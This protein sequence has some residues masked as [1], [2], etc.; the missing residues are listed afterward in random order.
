MRSEIRAYLQ[1]IDVPVEDDYERSTSET[2][3]PDGSHY[4]LELLPT[5]LD[6]YER[7]VDLASEHATPVNKFVDVTGTTFDS[8]ET[9]REKCRRCRDAGVQLLM[10]PGRGHHACDVSQQMALGEMDGGIVR[11][12]DNLVHALSEVKRASDLG[13]R[14]FNFQDEGLFRLC[15]RMRAD[16][17]LPADTVLKL[18]SSFSVSNPSSVAF[19]ADLLEPHDSVNLAR[20]LTLPML[21]AIRNVTDQPLDVHAFWHTEVVRT[22]DTPEI[23]RVAAPVSLKNYRVDHHGA[24]EITVEEQYEQSLRVA[25]TIDREFPEAVQFEATADTPGVPGT[26]VD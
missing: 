24:R 2:R 7:I 8:D 21:S 11:G 22:Q 13:C 25:E 18:S 12:M 23:V 14:G 3:F 5:E 16:G 17:E 26:P 4:K 20:D 6:E 19:W 1:R 15:A 10:E 9:I